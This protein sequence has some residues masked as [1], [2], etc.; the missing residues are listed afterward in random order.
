MSIAI[1]KSSF[2]ERGD[3]MTKGS[4]CFLCL[5]R[6]FIGMGACICLLSGFMCAMSFL[7]C[8]GNTLP[9]I[10]ATWSVGTLLFAMV[11][12][13]LKVIDLVLGCILGYFG[14]AYRFYYNDLI[15]TLSPQ[16]V[17][18]LEKFAKTLTRRERIHF[19]HTLYLLGK[20]LERV[21]SVYDDVW[22]EQDGVV[23]FDN[24]Y[25]YQISTNQK[26]VVTGIKMLTSVPKIENYDNVI[27][28]LEKYTV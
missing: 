23:V 17:L 5:I 1:G 11:H 26:G 22:Y 13:I 14:E 28:K 16:Q 4:Y 24:R 2:N 21:L 8:Y 6:K 9:S 3:R 25:R 20:P 7:M 18:S 19:F 27:K 12:V 10:S 15:P